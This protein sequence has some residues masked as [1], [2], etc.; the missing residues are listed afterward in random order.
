MENELLESFLDRD[1]AFRP[2]DIA[3]MSAGLEAALAKPGLVDRSDP[4]RLLEPT[5]KIA[6]Q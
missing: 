1:D 3:L 2:E 4:A 5:W 6:G